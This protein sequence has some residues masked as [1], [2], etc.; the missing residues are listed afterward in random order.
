MFKAPQH[1]ELNKR[2]SPE[3][4]DRAISTLINLG[5]ENGWLQDYEEIDGEFLP[6]FQKSDAWN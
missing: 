2:T 6:D 3:E 1:N 5:F 4:Y